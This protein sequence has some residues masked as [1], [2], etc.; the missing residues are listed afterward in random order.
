MIEQDY[1]DFCNEA[2]DLERRAEGYLAR[3]S[4]EGLRQLRGFVRSETEASRGK[5]LDGYTFL[6]AMMDAEIDERVR[7]PSKVFE[8][9]ILTYS[10]DVS[11]AGDRLVSTLMHMSDADWDRSAQIIQSWIERGCEE[12]STYSRVIEMVVYERGRIAAAHASPLDIPF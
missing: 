6:L 10:S 12:A 5:L 2:S 9:A 1:V 4:E 8:D 11:K 3:L 7:N